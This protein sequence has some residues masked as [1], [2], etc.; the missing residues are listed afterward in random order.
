MAEKIW[1]KA[2]QSIGISLKSGSTA[3]EV[4]DAIQTL[5]VR[6][7]AE[8]PDVNSVIRIRSEDPWVLVTYTWDSVI[9]SGDT[10]TQ[11]AVEDNQTAAWRGIGTRKG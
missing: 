10:G 11:P 9:H 5:A 4:A 8:D 1:T 7:K 3:D 6:A 2:T